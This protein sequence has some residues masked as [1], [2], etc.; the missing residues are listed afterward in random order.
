MFASVNLKYCTFNMSIT[1]DSNED[2]KEYIWLGPMKKAPSPQRNPKA[3][4]EHKTAT[5]N[6]DNTTIADRPRTVSLGNDCHPT[7]VIKPVNGIRTLPTN[8]K[9]CV[10]KMKHLK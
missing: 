9:S 7:S 3:T 2:K 6:F 4:W 8:R 5:K 10:I 1:D